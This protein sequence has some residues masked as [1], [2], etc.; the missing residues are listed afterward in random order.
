[1]SL[2]DIRLRSAEKVLSPRV[3]VGW[4]AQEDG[5]RKHLRLARRNQMAPCT[6]RYVVLG[7][8][9][10]EMDAT[11]TKKQDHRSSI[12]SRDCSR[13][14]TKNTRTQKAGKG[15]LASPIR[16][17]HLAGRWSVDGLVEGRQRQV[18]SSMGV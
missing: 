6:P 10:T 3:C 4:R 16:Y 7:G 14:S 15:L 18:H 11:K 17:V 13:D 8:R 9:C 1:M 12:I 2:T 5:S